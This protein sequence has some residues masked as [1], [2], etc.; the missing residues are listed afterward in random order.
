MPHDNV[1][2]HARTVGQ[3][4]PLIVLHGFLGTSDNWLRLAKFWA[5]RG[6]E[7]HLVDLRNHGKSFWD[8]EFNLEVLKEDLQNYIEFHKLK[9]PHIVG[10]SLGGK[11]AMAD[12]V[13]N[14]SNRGKYIIADIS[15]R[16]YPPHHQYI[17]EAV[18]KIH[19][20]ALKSRAEAADLLS[21]HIKDP[22]LAGFL[23]K[24]LK[25]LPEGGFA[26]SHNWEVLEQNADQIGE[27]LPPMSVYEKPI[28]FLKGEKSP[29]ITAEDIPLIYA[30][31]PKAR[32]LT[33]PG[34]GH[35]IHIDNP[36]FVARKILEFL[37]EKP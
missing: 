8:D 5:D 15:P 28:L 22:F 2:M 29:Y 35:L 9:Q 30:H 4:H 17:F 19:P 10:H 27:A 21:R 33:V 25:R 13:E 24:S 16:Y 37:E 7:V 12:A 32:I 3:G 1:V 34:A 11:I 26:W 18:K 14:R 20:R 6:Y 31:F 23:L 36:D